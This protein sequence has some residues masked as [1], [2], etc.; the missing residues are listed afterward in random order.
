MIG[1][2]HELGYH[3]VLDQVFNHTFEY[4]LAPSCTF[5][6]IVPGYYY[7][8]GYDGETL[9]TPCSRT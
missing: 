9:T 7:R 4:G 5:E 6:R 3:V 2:L 8:L 1:A